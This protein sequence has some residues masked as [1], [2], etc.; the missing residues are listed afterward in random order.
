MVLYSNKFSLMVE[1]FNQIN[2]LI[3]QFVLVVLFSF[4]I[5][6]ERSKKTSG[7]ITVFTFGTDR[8]FTL[9]GIL[10]YLLLIAD[11]Y[12]KMPYMVGFLILGLLMSIYYYTKIKSSQAYG[13][14]S[15]ILVLITY[16]FP[17]F[18]QSTSLWLS[19]LLFVTVL[20][21]SEVKKPLQRVILKIDEDE[22]AT[23]AKFIIITGIILP[24]LPTENIHEYLPV[25]PY[26]IWLAVVV[27]SVISYMSYLLQRYVFPKAGLLLT[28]ILGGLYSSTASTIILS[29]K[30]R[31]EDDK[32]YAYA[33]A[34]IVATAMMFLRIYILILIFIP[35]IALSSL[36]YVA[37]LFI[38]S[39][40][41]GLLLYNKQ[42][43]SA[44]LDNS[45]L[46]KNKNPLEF[47]V[48]VVFSLLYVIFSIITHL[49]FTYFG[50][51]GIAVLSIVVGVS[52][53]APFLLNLFQGSYQVGL[54][55]IIIATLQ[56]TA[57][58]NLLKAFYSHVLSGANTKRIVIKAF[59]L[60]TIFNILAVLIL[61]WIG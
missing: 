34:I 54:E 45:R 32:P 5:G 12:T 25:S 57:S 6:L 39:L 22:F 13:V 17:L 23:I 52:D 43:Q 56:A 20:I 38:S 58:N 1:L 18:I 31:K 26:K 11:S 42:K 51:S 8:T 24:I 3:I 27:V 49:V 29:R 14:T 7:Q 2:P 16:G 44:T 28:A 40:T 36:P 48:A 30:S 19:L 61:Y 50:E 41:T 53:I 47:K 4:S 55:I 33:G 37:F 10:G 59:A 21:L 46:L 9:I 15:I 60:I 35:Q